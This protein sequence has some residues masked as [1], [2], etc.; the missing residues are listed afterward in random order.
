M[1]LGSGYR[2]GESGLSEDAGFLHGFAVEEATIC[3]KSVVN[4]IALEK[5]YLCLIRKVCG[6]QVRNEYILIDGHA[7]IK[8]CASYVAQI[9]LPHPKPLRAVLRAPFRRSNYLLRFVAYQVST[10]CGVA[11]Y[12]PYRPIHAN[13]ISTMISCLKIPVE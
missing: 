11:K 9:L 2:T 6:A 3:H 1:W 13:R 12:L 7:S 5:F 4:N 8:A 10:C